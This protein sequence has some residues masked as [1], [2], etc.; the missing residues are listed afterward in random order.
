LTGIPMNPNLPHYKLYDLV[1]RYRTSTKKGVFDYG[2]NPMGGNTSGV[3]FRHY[4][5]V[6]YMHDI[7][8]A[9]RGAA[10]HLN[11]TQIKSI[12]MGDDRIYVRYTEYLEEQNKKATTYFHGY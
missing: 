11:A 7:K 1:N 3:E 6:N 4:R 8:A 9:T 2:S 10:A 5:A 12:S